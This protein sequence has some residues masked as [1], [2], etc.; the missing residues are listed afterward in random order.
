M[1]APF[2]L[3]IDAFVDDPA[4]QQR[5]IID[6]RSPSEYAEDHLPGAVNL[7]VLDDAERALVGT[8]DREQGSFAANRDGAAR[9]GRRISAMLE[10]PLAGKP[11]DWSPIV[12]CWRGGSRSWSL[13][14]VLARIGWKVSLLEGG[15]RG[16]RQRVIA[17]TARLAPTLHLVVLAGPTGVGKTRLLQLAADA[18]HQ[19]LDLEALANH[20]GSV[21]GARPDVP[22]PSQKAFESRLWRALRAIDPARPVLVESESRK[23]GRLH[24]PDPVIGAMR[25]ARCI[26]IET[27]TATRIALLRD[28]YRHFEED[29][30]PLLAQLDRL[31][32]LHADGRVKAWRGHVERGD[33]DGLV[34][35]L[36]AQHYDPAYFRSMRRNY[37]GIDAAP[38]LALDGASDD[39]F[40]AAVR[41]LGRLIAAPPDAIAPA[42]A[43]AARA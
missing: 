17:D 26:R 20:R 9:V 3:S 4:L 23:I 41:G 19:V 42:P 21:L 40:E 28:E 37:V 31:E 39:A 36:L 25:A 33:W 29:P 13:A 14:T 32:P 22:Q 8:L 38:Q 7:P 1:K 27:S 35:A 43:P 10:G 30:A 16:F 18:G 12:Y 15:Y 6:V 11:K 2:P 24:L 34:A 5:D